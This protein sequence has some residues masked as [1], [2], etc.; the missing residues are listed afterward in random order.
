M[1]RK[2][3]TTLAGS[4]PL[5]QE[6]LA[7][8]AAAVPQT[9]P[10][11]AESLAEGTL[12]SIPIDEPSQT[13][14]ENTVHPGRK[15]Y[16]GTAPVENPLLLQTEP[17]AAKENPEGT[18]D[19]DKFT[20]GSPA[21]DENSAVPQTESETAGNAV[22]K[23]KSRRR[24]AKT[25]EDSAENSQSAD[26]EALPEPTAPQAQPRAARRGRGILSIDEERTV[27]TR[28]D[29]VRNDLLDLVESLKV[30]KILTGTVQGVERSDDN[31]DICYAVLYHGEFKVIIPAEA[32]V[33]TPEDFRDQKPSDVMYYL[34]T[35][36]LGAEVDYIIK[37]IDSES[38]V[39]AA[40]RLEAMALK[41]R[42]YYFGTARV[43]SNLV[44][45]GSNAEA[46]VVSVIRN[47]IFVDLFGL[48]VY[49]PL[50]ELSYQRWTDAISHYQSGQ[51]VLVK[52]LS[53]DRT[54]K[55][56]IHVEASVK[57]AGPNPYELALRRYVIGCR[58]VGTV[59]LVNTTGVFVS[60]DGGID[61]LCSHPKR[62][63]P[64]RGSRV[65]VRILGIDHGTNRIWGAITHMTA[66]R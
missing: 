38:D 31:P 24:R 17:E 18:P 36:R 16:E 15:P 40:S 2:T 5:L 66:S 34:V 50:R 55:D 62:G 12:K 19:P 65:T 13:D 8:E 47:G 20:P 14:P 23:T 28:H 46:R 52:V 61:C 1:P 48:E 41:R 51:R 49:I 45:E 32:F 58:Y 64:P 43:G 63:R 3:T 44:M 9:E 10:D 53:V 29:N 27:A 21:A 39:A 60:L 56:N 30:K 26:E 57:Q 35:K 4:E 37:G 42:Q 33:D 59:S 25:Q 54:S 11:Q 22:S 6:N 7:T